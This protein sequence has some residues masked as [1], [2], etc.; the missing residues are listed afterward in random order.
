MGKIKQGILGGFNGTTG[1]V[2]GASWK[3]IAYMRGKAQSIK[4][5]RTEAQQDNRA[6]F[7]SLS[8]FLARNLALINIGFNERAVKK[9]AYNA[10]LSI[11]AKNGSFVDGDLVPANIELSAGSL[12]SPLSGATSVDQGQVYVTANAPREGAGYVAGTKAVIGA[13]TNDG[14]VLMY[15]EVS[16]TQSLQELQ[17]T[18][19]VQDF[20]P[21]TTVYG[22]CFV[23]DPSTGKASFMARCGSANLS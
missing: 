8:N 7:G 10:S 23:Y 15:T 3:G 6:N 4:N 11:N 16:I 14:K 1:S 13:Y 20:E 9:S 21:S 17:F 5:P 12:V 18:G 19:T 22:F 2:V